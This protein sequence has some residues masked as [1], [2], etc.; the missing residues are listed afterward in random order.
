[1]PADNRNQKSFDL[2]E[3]TWFT[4]RD[5]FDD[6]QR[7]APDQAGREKLLANRDG[8]RDAY[9]QAVGK[10]FDEQDAFVRGV[11]K[12]LEGMTKDLKR[13]IRDLQNIVSVLSLVSSSVRLAAALSAMSVP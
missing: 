2:I 5:N 13:E 10:I 7:N 12:E 3:D 6:L 8:A 11:K 4:L 9:Y 1:M